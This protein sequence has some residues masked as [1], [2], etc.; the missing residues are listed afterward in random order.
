MS[1]PSD[2][3]VQDEILT[4]SSKASSTV[5][6]MKYAAA[7]RAEL[8]TTAKCTPATTLVGP[9]TV[10]YKSSFPQRRLARK[11]SS[12]QRRWVIDDLLCSIHWSKRSLR[13]LSLI[14]SDNIVDRRRPTMACYQWHDLR[15]YIKRLQLDRRRDQS[16]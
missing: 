8:Q 1:L 10:A 15:R 14:V 13:L 9:S 3:V 5:Q 4:R 6:W 7:Y 12:S 11:G 2:A 16:R